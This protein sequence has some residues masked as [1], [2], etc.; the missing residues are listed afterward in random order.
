MHATTWAIPPTSRPLVVTVH[1]V[2][3]LRDQPLH[4]S[5]GAAYFNQSHRADA[6]IVPSE[7]TASRRASTRDSSP[8]SRTASP[9]PASPTP[10]V[11]FRAR[12]GRTR[13]Y[14]LW[15]GTREPRKNLPTLGCAHTC[16][17]LV[18]GSHPSSWAPPGGEKTPEWGTC[19]L[20]APTSSD[21]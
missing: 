16:H 12:H 7:A 19:P 5:H 3:F 21:A 1:D 15:V 4:L 11:G 10:Q 6:V 17:G 18:H 9:T 20:N 14:I 2:A 13:P 8:S